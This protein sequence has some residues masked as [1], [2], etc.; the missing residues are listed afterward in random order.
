MHVAE[1]KGLKRTLHGKHRA[2]CTAGRA[3]PPISMKYDGFFEDEGLKEY[4]DDAEADTIRSAMREVEDWM[5][6][7]D[8]SA[9]AATYEQKVKRLKALIDPILKRRVTKEQETFKQA[10]AAEQPIEEA[11]AAGPDTDNVDAEATPKPDSAEA[12]L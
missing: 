8:G 4:Y 12:E 7:A 10:T 5:E 3:M 2:N 1:C 6:Q 11:E 9:T